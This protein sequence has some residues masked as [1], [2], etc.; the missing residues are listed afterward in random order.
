M[1]VNAEVARVLYEI[2]ELFTIKGDRYRSRAFLTAAQRVSSLTED[3]RRIHERNELTEIPGVG[4]SIAAV[5]EEVLNTGESSQ[6][7]E[8][9]EALPHG[10]RDLMELEG[11]GP[12]TALRL[13]DELGVVSIE[14]LEEAVKAGKLR[15]LKGFGAKTEENILKSIEAHRMRAGAFPPRRDSPRHRPDHLPH[16]QVRSRA[17]REARGLRPPKEGDHRR[18]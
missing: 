16:V 11:I 4:K 15:A 9:R 5:I 14:G 7:E 3:V 1:S 8:L 12:K 6:L 13:H 18:P 10:V 17:Q 2:G